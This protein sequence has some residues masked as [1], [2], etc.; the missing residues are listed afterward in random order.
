MKAE[1]QIQLPEVTLL[2]DA[3]GARPENA[4]GIGEFWYQPEVWALPLSPAARVLYAGLCSYL[5]HG[6]VNRKDLRETLKGNTDREI[7]EALQELV[8][9]AL[10]IPASAKSVGGTLPAYEVRPLLG[11]EG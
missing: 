1:D 6:Q 11:L 9:H 7:S 8:R 4:V 3:R 2:S 10:L 5:G